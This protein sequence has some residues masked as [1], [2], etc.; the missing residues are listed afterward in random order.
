[1]LVV[2]VALWSAVTHEKSELGRMFI[3]NDGTGDWERGNYDV[4]LADPSLSIR[5]SFATPR[6]MARVENWARNRTVWA[7][8]RKA[9]AELGL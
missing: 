1:M 3:V 9:L 5:D 2:Q 8:T 7:L 6:K 4:L